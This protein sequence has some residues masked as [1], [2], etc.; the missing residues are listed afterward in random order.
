MGYSG[1]TIRRA[2]QILG[3][4]FNETNGPREYAVIDGIIYT[5]VFEGDP[6]IEGITSYKKAFNGRVGGTTYFNQIILTSK[7]KTRYMSVD[8]SWG[9]CDFNEDIKGLLD[10]LEA[11]PATTS[12]SEAD[13]KSKKIEDF[14]VTKGTAEETSANVSVIL[15]EGYGF[16]ISRP[17]ILD[18]SPEQ[19]YDY[20]HF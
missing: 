14:S 3:Y 4:G 8:A 10:W 13:V 7:C 16:Y 2:Q 19:R 15:N 18:V 1:N 20:R 5:D 11:N 17:L 6:T 9:S 12:L